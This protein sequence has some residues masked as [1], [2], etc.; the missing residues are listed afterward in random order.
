MRWDNS[1][2]RESLFQV[3]DLL[4]GCGGAGN[5]QGEH[6]RCQTASVA[7]DTNSLALEGFAVDV[8]QQTA[9]TSIDATAVHVTALSR[10]LN[11]GLHALV[12]A[13]LGQTHEGL[14]HD[15][16]GQRLLVIHISELRRNITKSWCRRVSEV[17]VVEQAAIGLGNELAGRSM[18]C[19]VVKSVKRGL[20][21][22]FTSTVGVTVG[23]VGKSLQLSFPCIVGSVAGIYS[24]CVTLHGELAIDDGV[25]ASKIWL[26]E[27]VGVSH[28]GTSQTWLHG[29]WCIRAD[30]HSYAT[31]SASG[32]RSSLG[33]ERNVSSHDDGVS[34]IPGRRLEP[35]DGVEE[36]VGTTVASIH[37]IHTLN[38]G[39]F[40][41]QLHEDRLDGLGLVEDGLGTDFETSNGVGVD[42]VLA[43]Q[44]RDGGKCE[45]VDIWML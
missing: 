32:S 25:F 2:S 21:G 28:V 14:L 9:K 18:E 35:V 10:H 1:A 40:T 16:I 17:I 30:Q 26:V 42:L 44:V 13:L 7:E 45:R 34:S 23:T 36:G 15:L 39:V 4:D 6:A 38:R 27:V 11:A 3:Q 29:E 33:I 8:R 5:L 41:K 31:S 37:G 20:C 43:Q 22:L 19:H 24:L 12:E